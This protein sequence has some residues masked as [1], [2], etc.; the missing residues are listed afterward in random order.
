MVP[1]QWKSRF[2]YKSFADLRL[3]IQLE[4]AENYTILSCCADNRLTILIGKFLVIIKLPQQI[5]LTVNLQYP[6]FIHPHS[7]PFIFILKYLNE[8]KVDISKLITLTLPEKLA[9]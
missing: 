9:A 5:D 7:P 4:F 1:S 8:K 3:M 2:S 6:D